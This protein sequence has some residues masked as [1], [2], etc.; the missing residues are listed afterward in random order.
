MAMYDS[1]E[2]RL[3][4]TAYNT[5]SAIICSTIYDN[6]C[7]T[8]S[9][10]EYRVELYKFIKTI[11]QLC[12]RKTQKMYK[13]A[14]TSKYSTYTEEETM[15]THYKTQLMLCDNCFNQNTLEIDPR[16][17]LIRELIRRME[18]NL[19]VKCGSDMSEKFNTVTHGYEAEQFKDDSNKLSFASLL[20]RRGSAS[21][22]ST[23]RG[24][25]CTIPPLLPC[26]TSPTP[27]GT[28]ATSSL[29]V[30]IPCS[31]CTT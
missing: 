4:H 1:I 26:W 10:T 11:Q 18:N 17:P 30:R 9:N 16:N 29:S 14:P 7:S 23:L 21:G 5:I 15:Q 27:R 12:Y 6:D 31:P 13:D 3:S 2:E 22:S 8:M 25:S 19:T 24:K 20:S 28:G